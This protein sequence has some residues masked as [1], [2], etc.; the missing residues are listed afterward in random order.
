MYHSDTRGPWIDVWDFDPATGGRQ[1]QAPV[2][3]ARR[4]HRPARGG[5]V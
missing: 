1:Q 3:Q 2:C 5:S 4:R